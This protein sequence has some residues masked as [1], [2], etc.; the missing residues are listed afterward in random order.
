MDTLAA[1]DS[2][3]GNM[4]WQSS[5]AGRV[6][7]L[8]VANGTLYASTDQ[9]VIQSFRPTASVPFVANSD[10]EKETNADLPPLKPIQKVNEASL[11][12]RWVFHQDAKEG[13]VIRNLAGELTANLVGPAKLARIDDKQA[14]V[15]DGSTSALIKGDLSHL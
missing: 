12:S 9:G 2:V 14:L 13:K 5:I 6:Y 8:A 11:M 7:G 10:S 15:L 3:T 1:F 4:T